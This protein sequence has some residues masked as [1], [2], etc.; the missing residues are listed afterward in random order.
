MNIES[1]LFNIL[2]GPPSK[3]DLK[4][5][6]IIEA[7]I[8]LF[9]KEG[10]EKTNYESLA[11]MI[12]TRR[13]HIAYYF[14]DKSLIFISSVRYILAVYQELSAKNVSNAASKRDKITKYVETIFE[15]AKKYPEQVGVM[16]LLYYQCSVNEEY[17]KLN[18]DIRAQGL[19][20]I[21]EILR[22]DLNLKKTDEKMLA[23]QIQNLLS[24]SIIEAMTTTHGNL[25]KVKKELMNFL[26]VLLSSAI[27]Q[28]GKDH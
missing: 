12:G 1:K 23:K 6:E 24:A 15:W 9:A 3:G 11:K 14:K 13:A 17:K 16:L 25:D 19:L 20:K 5:L 8:H 7:A 28:D 26:E 22:E 2:E 21:E 27:F 18:D 4:R 10:L